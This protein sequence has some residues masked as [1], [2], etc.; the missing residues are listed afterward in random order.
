MQHPFLKNTPELN[1]F[2]SDEKGFLDFKK[3]EQALTQNKAALPILT[4]ISKMLHGATKGKPYHL[5]ELDGAEGDLYNYEVTFMNIKKRLQSFSTQKLD[6]VSLQ[7]KETA[8]LLSFTHK[9]QDTCK[10]L[11][12]LEELRI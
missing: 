4:N 6:Q 7:K 5:R 8:A 12:Y 11:C 2:L 10:K 3:K 9:L 1:I